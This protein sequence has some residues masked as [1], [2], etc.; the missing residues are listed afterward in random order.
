MRRAAEKLAQR[1]GGPD[2]G[3]QNQLP[4]GADERTVDKIREAL[5]EGRYEDAL[6]MM[7]Q[8]QDQLANLSEGLQQE[9]ES[10]AG[11]KSS[12]ELAEAMN[13]AIE[14]TRQL[15]ER[16]AALA[17]ETD[18]LIEK[19][20]SGDGLDP[21][22][23]ESILKEMD[24]VLKAIARIP[25]GIEEP[26]FQQRARRWAGRAEAV[27]DRMR[28]AFAEGGVEE[29]IAS[30]MQAMRELDNTRQGLDVRSE[31]DFAVPGAKPASLRAAKAS[32]RT[33]GVVQK[34]EDAL[35][36]SERQRA[37]GGRGGAST[38]RG[39]NG[40][41]GDVAGLRR[42][43]EEMGGSAFNPVSGRD[44][45]RAA[46][47]LMLRA[48][49][50]LEQ[51]RPGR[52]RGA[53]DGASQQLKQFRESLEE[54]Q[55]SMQQGSMPRPGGMAQGPQSGRGNPWDRMEDWGGDE[56]NGEVEMPEPDDFLG[57][58]AFRRLV[59]EG[60]ADDA[61]ERYRPLNGSYYEELV[62]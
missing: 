59:L 45:L 33:A 7:Q 12:D 58:D 62:R 20:G 21:K 26:R 31:G 4:S 42:R 3:F 47:D 39:Q 24:E 32:E 8:A 57:P 6:R 11:S 28:G 48:G 13:E 27:A 55:A 54:A 30:G 43:V 36:R 29:A 56:D 1:R 46:E 53:Q 16:Q 14:Q 18:G 38:K 22:A 60:A 15:E 34:L 51:G 61:P 37:A 9:M 50:R 19:F 49:A 17:G 41:A 10:M 2:D 44:S 5:E 23:Q 25:E 35:A 40:L 52:A